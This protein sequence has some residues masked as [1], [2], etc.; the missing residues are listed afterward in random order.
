MADRWT[1]E[2]EVAETVR[3]ASRARVPIT[4][5]D[6]LCRIQRWDPLLDTSARRRRAINHVLDWGIVHG[7]YHE[8]ESIIQTVGC[9]ACWD[10]TQ[11]K[12][13]AR[14]EGA[15]YFGSDVARG[16][17]GTKPLRW[18]SDLRQWSFEMRMHGPLL[19]KETLARG[20]IALV[21]LGPTTA[22]TRL[23]E[24]A[25]ATLEDWAVLP[26]PHNQAN[27]ATILSA[28]PP[29]ERSRIALSIATSSYAR[30]PHRFTQI[31]E[32]V[33][34]ECGEVAVRA[35][36]ARDLGDWAL[37]SA[38]VGCQD[39]LRASFQARLASQLN[40]GLAPELRCCLNPTCHAHFLGR[41][42]D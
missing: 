13:H 37:D 11:S 34:A 2:D 9:R 31:V 39:P 12:L 20:A 15:A 21:R 23:E 29:S 24:A 5:S 41:P 19:G 40:G 8:A 10:S 6:L 33:A 38:D 32:D 1:F 26:C 14:A 17:L 3:S 28:A 30:A 42:C 4:R 27:C 16:A 25:L 18:W 7:Q 36:L 22:R 35:T